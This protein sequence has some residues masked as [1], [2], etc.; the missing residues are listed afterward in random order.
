M[1]PFVLIH[2]FLAIVQ[3]THTAHKAK[4]FV[5][6]THY[7]IKY[8]ILQMWQCVPRAR[9]FPLLT[10]GYSELPLVDRP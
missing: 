4:F 9:L 5:P 7:Q 6:F 10:R 8:D 1:E 3:H 2:G